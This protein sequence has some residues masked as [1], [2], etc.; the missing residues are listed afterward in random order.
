MVR[1]GAYEGCGFMVRVWVY[2][3]GG[4]FMVRVEVYGKVG[5]LW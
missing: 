5:G 2:G 1:V 4:G 3:K